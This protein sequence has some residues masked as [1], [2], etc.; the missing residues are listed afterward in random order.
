MSAAAVRRRFVALTALRWL[1]TGLL[2]PVTVVFMQSRG[3]SLAQVG[4]VSA[5]Q[6]LVV[7][8]LELP[9]GGLADALGRRPVLL[10]AGVLNLVSLGVFAAARSPGAFMAAWAIQGVYRALDSGPLESLFVDAS[11]AADPR[12]D[13]ERGLA[14]AGT[15]IGAAI[16]AGSLATAALARW[17][18]GGGEGAVDPLVVPVL[19]ALVLAAAGL[20][21][22]AAGL[23]E[24]RRRAADGAPVTVAAAAAEAPRVVARTVALVVGSPVLLALAAVELSWGAGLVGVELFS[25]PRLVDLVGTATGG[26]ATFALASAAGWTVSAAGSALT[27]RV[28]GLAGGSAVRVA[29]W[30]RIVQGAAAL[31]MALVGGPAALVA[32]YLGFY[33]VHGTANVVHY[34]LLHRAVGPGHRTT[35]LSASS[36]VSRAGGVA[37]ALVLGAVADRAGPAWALGL[38]GVVLAAAA[39]LYRIAGRRRPGSAGHAGRGEGV[40]RPGAEGGQVAGLAAGHE[41]RAALPVDD[42]LLVDPA[43]AGV[44]EVGA[45]AGPACQAA[46]P[47]HAGVDQRPGGMADG[48]HR[49]AQLEERAHEV[50]G[51][52]VQ[53][54]AVGVGHAAREDEAGEALGV[55]LAADD[56]DAEDVGPV[57]VVERPDLAALGGDEHGAPALG[58]HR[59]PGLGQ[60]DLLDP[61]VGHQEGDLGT[62]ES[63]G[64]GGLLG[65]AT[66]TP[67]DYPAEGGENW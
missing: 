39:P 50:H 33:L 37:A 10:V 60:L 27:G 21:A 35:V 41:D 13:I 66:G 31:A 54:Q 6:G 64:H 57:E 11:L 52:R 7:L 67:R 30:L 17:P 23:P 4:L 2:I 24:P 43:G 3:L 63:C 62:G 19:A 48:G 42:H 65:S 29:A 59:R 9:T 22:L 8:V 34:G 45:Q 47:H 49:R 16:G 20:A 32:G 14:H 28:V 15:A 44:G 38:A 58:R 36:L 55:G 56:V 61:L 1:P 40:D 46:V 12:A 5:T 51:G 25:A 18:V 53:A 26:V